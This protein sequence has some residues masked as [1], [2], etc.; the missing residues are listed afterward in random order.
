MG[1]LFQAVMNRFAHRCGQIRASFSNGSRLIAQNRRADRRGR[2]PFKRPL[3]TRHL[4]QHNA[5]RK[6]VRPMVDLLA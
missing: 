1:F 2:T 3:S 5:H 4:I 6:N